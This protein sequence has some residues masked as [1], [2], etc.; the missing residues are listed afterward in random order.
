MTED[1][2][3]RGRRAREADEQ[4]RRIHSARPRMPALA[5]VVIGSRAF[6]RL[7]QGVEMHGGKGPPALPSQNGEE[8]SDAELRDLSQNALISSLL[9]ALMRWGGR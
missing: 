7:M 5:R 6:R 8:L 2:T 1:I 4:A 9:R 3:M